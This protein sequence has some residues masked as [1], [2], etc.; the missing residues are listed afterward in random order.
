MNL[1]RLLPA[2]LIL[3]AVGPSAHAQQSRRA[4]NEAPAPSSLTAE[5][6]STNYRLTLAAKSGD[7]A[8][9]EISVLTC[10]RKIDASGMLDK[11]ADDTLPS[12]LLS[13]QGTLTEQ[14]GGAL[15]LAYSFG[16]STPVVSQTMS[17]G[18][19]SAKRTEADAKAGDAK[20]AAEARPEQRGSVSS[21]ITYRDHLSSG[22][23]RVK[24][25]SSYDLVTMA[26]VVYSLT[27]TPEAQK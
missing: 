4:T 3:L 20:A 26:G 27:I 17:F 7:K 1:A 5:T 11:P 24:A 22:S 23:V 9:G 19:S 10:A 18:G 2:A 25:G 8:L 14:E 13:I 12:T 16:V 21:V 6:L 15:M